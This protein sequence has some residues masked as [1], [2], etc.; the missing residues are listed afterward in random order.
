MAERATV[1]RITGVRFSPIALKTK[2]GK[3]KIQNAAKKDFEEYYKLKMEDF[4]EYSKLIGMKIT[5]TKKES[6]TEFNRILSSKNDLLLLMKEKNKIIGFVHGT[7][8]KISDFTKAN[9][10]YLY[11]T[12]E[13]RRKGVAEKL[14]KEFIKIAKSEKAKKLFLK[15][16]INN[17][18]AIR[19][20]KKLNFEITNYVMAKKLK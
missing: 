9:I 20:Y 1:A 19:L 4:N 10:E 12:K 8:I 6:N 7:I 14:I 11:V 3:M 2:R 5:S 16:N 15:V 17:E 13:Y 18:N